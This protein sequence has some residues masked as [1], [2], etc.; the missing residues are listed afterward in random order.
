MML[1]GR[2]SE[3]ADREILATLMMEAF[4]TGPEDAA[5]D[6]SLQQWKYWS[7]H[8]FTKEG[9]SDL[10]LDSGAA[11]AHACRW[12]IRLLAPAS[13]AKAFHLTDWVA[14]PREPGAGLQML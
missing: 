12:P 13:G 7:P 10:L 1:Q 9:R 8:P 3:P 6:P 14:A 11:V 5:L 2:A 4:R